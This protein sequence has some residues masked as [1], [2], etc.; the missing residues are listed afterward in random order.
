MTDYYAT[1]KSIYPK[2]KRYY[3]VLVK[4]GGK[5]KTAEI[6]F[7]EEKTLRGVLKE[8]EGLLEAEIIEDYEGIKRI[9]IKP[10]EIRIKL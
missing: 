3:P 6:K 2:Q 5:I 1:E 10:K 4:H 8:I 9:L 7:N